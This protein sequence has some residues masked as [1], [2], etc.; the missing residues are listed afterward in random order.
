MSPGDP[1]SE[2]GSAPLRGG[3]LVTGGAR[4]LGLEIARQLLARG[5]VVHLTDL[6]GELAQ[7]AAREL[8][9]GAFGSALD[10]RSF[11]ACRA[12]ANRIRRR[13][14]SLEVW[15]NNAGVLHTGPAWEQDER[16]RA[17][18][19][20]VNATGTINGTVAA[21]EPMRAAGHGHIINVISLAGLIAA[22]GGAIYSASKHAAIAFSFATLA[23]LRLA[24]DDAIEIS[25][26]CPDGVWTPMLLER[27]DDPDAAAM[28]TGVMY[29]PDRVAQR[30][31]ALLD[32]PRPLL[33]MPRW[34]GT[35]VRVFDA[36]PGLGLRW[37]KPMLA[38][39]RRRQR[40]YRRKRERG[41]L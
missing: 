38:H 7:N 30:V 36:L 8:G 29:P 5:H 24:G 34:R 32:S 9:P 39:G 2:N 40:G 14:G 16:T 31:V 1:V 10:V 11:P 4:G 17:L 41:K 20:D 21:L 26:V 25:C 27:L 28:F 13:V 6:D 23:D 12:A 18:M 3:A 19:L 15:V 33:V 35:L 37:L 22:P